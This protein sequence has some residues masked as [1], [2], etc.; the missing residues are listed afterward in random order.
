MTNSEA[1][2]RLASGVWRLASG[3]ALGSGVRGL[4]DGLGSGAWGLGS[5]CW[6]FREALGSLSLPLSLGSPGPL[7]SRLSAGPLK[8]KNEK[9]R[10]WSASL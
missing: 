5:G 8:T 6:V 1:P 4:A 7:G 3:V 10:T 2:V 9:Q